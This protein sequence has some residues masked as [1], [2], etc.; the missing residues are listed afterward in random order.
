VADVGDR[1]ALMAARIEA[2][3]VREPVT[4]VVAGDSGAWADPTAD[5]IFSELVRQ[6]AELDPPPLFFA[7][8]GDFAGPGTLERHEHY[9]RLVAPLRVPNVCVVGNHDLDD[10]GGPD[11]FARVHGPTN[12]ALRDRRFGET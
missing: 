11:A 1:N 10:A 7:N 5:A 2:A 6:V 4:F 12:F 9:V 3:P 8:L